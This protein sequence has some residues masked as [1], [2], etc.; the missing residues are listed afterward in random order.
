MKRTSIGRHS[1]EI[2]DSIDELPI[3]RFHKFNKMLL[4][5][6]GV[7][8]D[9]A[10]FDRH[11]ERAMAYSRSKTPELTS[12]ELDNLRQNVYFIQSGLSPRHLAFAVLV[13][14]IDG[15]V[16]EDLSDEALQ[17]VVDLLA[18]VTVKDMTAH[19]DAVKK[20]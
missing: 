15:K 4:I 13:S 7:G 14:S 20:K 16:C 17:G 9:L 11:I 1:V 19:F 10:D 8:S 2:Y 5:D 3:R 18:D 6:A 12:T